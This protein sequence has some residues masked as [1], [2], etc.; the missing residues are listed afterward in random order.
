MAPRVPH[1]RPCNAYSNKVLIGNWF[2]ERVNAVPRV[3]QVEI[4]T[5]L[6]TEL[7][8][9]KPYSKVPID[10]V[11]DQRMDREG[12]IVFSQDLREPPNFFD[13]Y[14]STYDLSY[15]HFPKCYKRNIPRILN[16]R[17]GYHEPIEEYLP[18]FGNITNFGLLDYKKEKWNFEKE[19]VRKI[20]SSVYKEEFKAPEPADY[21]FK[22]YVLQLEKSSVAKEINFLD[23]ERKRKR[24]GTNPS[25]ILM[26]RK[27]NQK[28]A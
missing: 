4:P 19:G 14:S 21:K 9:C 11:W 20:S 24:S 22:R 23:L 12:G 16:F 3:L 26:V 28:C 13:N 2:D 18:S 25:T 27:E 7:Y 15:N 1:A 10:A 17:E 6:Y 5:T 8:D